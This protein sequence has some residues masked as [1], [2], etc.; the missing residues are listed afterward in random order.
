MFLFLR[1]TARG[2]ATTKETSEPNYYTANEKK[3]TLYLR[4]KIVFGVRKRS[5]QIRFSFFCS[6]TAAYD[7][8]QISFV[9][10]IGDIILNRYVIR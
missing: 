5:T 4:E 2:A 10:L 9:K 7:C 8:H 1:Q 6:K 3:G